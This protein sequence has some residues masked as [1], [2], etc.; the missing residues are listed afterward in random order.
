MVACKALRGAGVVVWGA[1]LVSAFAHPPVASAGP[2]DVAS[3]DLRPGLAAHYRSLAEGEA[4]L[5]RIDAKPAF[6]L[7]YS[8]P[9]PRIPPG[10]FEVVWTGVLELKDAGPIRFD[11]YL[12]G[13]ATVE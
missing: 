7:G 8:N 4:R 11:A 10:P 9:H 13:E 2:L 5:A 6:S 3:D 12:C 1:I